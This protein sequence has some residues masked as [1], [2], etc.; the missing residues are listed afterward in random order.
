MNPDSLMIGILL[1]QRQEI[2]NLRDENRAL[3]AELEAAYHAQTD[4][5]SS[6]HTSEQ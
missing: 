5:P 2:V 6:A 3:R 1:E 4:S